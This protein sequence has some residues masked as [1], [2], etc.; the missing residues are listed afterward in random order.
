MPD[1]LK[2]LVVVLVVASAVFLVARA[3]VCATAMAPKDF[4]RRRNLWFALV[5]TVF[6]AH[7]FWLFMLVAGVLLFAAQRHEPNK[8]A[9]FF[10]LLLA[11]PGISQEIPT[12]GVLSALFEIDYPRLLA[13]TVLLPV[14]LVFRKRPGVEPFGRLLPDKVLLAYLILGFFLT[15]HDS[16]LTIALRK[17]FFYALVDVFLP[18]YVASRCVRNLPRFRDVLMAFV[19]A[20]LVL[21]PLLFFEFAKTWLLY[22]SLDHA[23]GVH[24]GW[25]GFLL[26][27]GNLR[28]TG[29]AGHPIVAGYVIAIAAAFFIYFRKLVPN[30]RLWLFGMLLLLAGLMAPLSRGPWVGAAAMA[31]IFVATGPAP[32]VGFAR[33]AMIAVLTV[34]LLLVS[35]AGPVIIDHLPWIGTIE[36]HNVEG[37]ERLAV[38]ATGVIMENPFFGSNDFLERPEMEALRGPEGII[39]LVNTYVVIGLRSGLI[40]LSLFVGFFLVVGLRVHTGMRSLPDRNGE[41]YILGQTLIAALVGILITIA[42]VAPVLAVPAI[43]WSVA[44]LGVGYALMLVRSKVAQPA[45][46]TQPVP[47]TGSRPAG[48]ASFGSPTRS[49]H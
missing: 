17:G 15:L 48:P 49:P 36:A 14:Y 11:V 21:S 39:D 25:S 33:L 5:L 34:P 12:F 38:V 43:Y 8:F 31:L 10:F 2:A 37:R 27:G 22:S 19:V 13:L 24:W 7:N 20:A 42:T 28:A 30:R 45:G 1:H 26:R 18:Y 4:A 46:H 9:M 47:S 44:G 23:L 35:P 6:L 41:R 40:G 3:P 32:V 29:S 16:N